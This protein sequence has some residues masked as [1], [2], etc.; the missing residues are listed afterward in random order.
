MYKYTA[1]IVEP[2]EHRALSFVLNNFLTNLSEEWGIIIFHGR[3]NKKYIEDILSTDLLIYKHRIKTLIQLD[4]DNLII[5]QYNILLKNS[6]FYKC[7]PTE[8]LLI[9]Q[10]DSII[11]KENK[12]L[13]NNFLEYDYVGAPWRNGM[14]GNG[15]LC[16]RSKSK[17]IEICEKVDKNF[18]P[19]EDNY[20]CYQNT[21]SLNRPSFQDAQ[22]FSVETVFHEKSFGIHAPWKY[23]TTYE[24]EFLIHRYPDINTLKELNMK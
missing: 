20:F 9:F 8:I 11:L 6:N 21:V 18:T 4:V 17:M 19:H 3:K 1:V 24:L 2:R 14:V 5:N 22:K 16:L 13:I 23:L 12:D 10:V 15:G 7:I